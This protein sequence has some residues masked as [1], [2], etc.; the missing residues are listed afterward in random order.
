[1]NVLAT[2]YRY[3]LAVLLMAAFFRSRLTLSP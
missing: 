1:M 3:P 2:R